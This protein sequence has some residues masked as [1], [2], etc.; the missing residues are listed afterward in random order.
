MT[1]NIRWM[2]N[3]KQ[4][5][6]TIKIGKLF[7]SLDMGFSSGHASGLWALAPSRNCLLGPP[8]F[9]L[10]I[11]MWA[12]SLTWLNSFEHASSRKREA[13]SCLFQSHPQRSK[14]VSS[15]LIFLL[16]NAYNDTKHGCWKYVNVCI[17]LWFS[18]LMSCWWKA[19]FVFGLFDILCFFAVRVFASLHLNCAFL[20][21]C[22][23]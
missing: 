20:Q 14:S 1:E 22:A 10:D 7:L 17:V 12:C 16:F 4:L 13:R 15:K 18:S 11:S 3:F 21:P 23:T 5:L 2:M 8:A 19:F 6:V 9:V